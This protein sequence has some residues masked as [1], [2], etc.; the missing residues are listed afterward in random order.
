MVFEFLI[1]IDYTG[2]SSSQQRPAIKN[3]DLRLMMNELLPGGY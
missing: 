1:N 3:F 2:R